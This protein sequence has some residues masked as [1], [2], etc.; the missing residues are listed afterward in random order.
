MVECATC[1]G[2]KQVPCQTC[3]KLDTD[4]CACALLHCIERLI[5]RSFV[6]FADSSHSMCV[7]L[8]RVMSSCHDRANQSA[9][10]VS[11]LVISLALIVRRPV[12]N[13]TR[14]TP[15]NRLIHSS[16]PIRLPLSKPFI[17]MQRILTPR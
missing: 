15:P 11:I 2:E 6:S 7:A 16:T 8:C 10:C 14:H 4:V 9:R 12:Y 13:V 3:A 5:V 1:K 17:K